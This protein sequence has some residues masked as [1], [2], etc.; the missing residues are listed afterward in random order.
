MPQGDGEVARGRGYAKAA[1][2]HEEEGDREEASRLY[3]KAAEAF[4]AGSKVTR[5]PDQR[6]LRTELA[7][8]FYERGR[9]LKAPRRKRIR[10]G[11]SPTVEEGEK[12]YFIPLEV[13]KVTFRD[14][15]GMER[16]KE[17]I[18]KAIIHPFSHP[19]LYEMYGKSAGESILFYGPPGCGKT[20]IAKAAAG[21]TRSSFI[22]VRIS[23]VLNMWAGESEKNIQRV[24]ASAERHKPAIIFFDEIDGIG[25]R[26]SSSRSTYAKR[27]VN[28]MLIAMDGIQSSKDKILTLAATNEPWALDPALIRPGRFSKLI[29]IPPPDQEARRQIFRLGLEGRRSSEDLDIE[30]LAARTRCY[31]SADIIQICEEAAE[32][33]LEEALRGNPPRPIDQSD[34]EGIIA[35]RRSSLIPWFR[36][37]RKQIDRSG[38]KDIYHELS[39][40]IDGY[41]GPGG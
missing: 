11:E 34:I 22:N 21:E 14:V 33:P 1:R 27:L 8:T 32:I 3:L 40:I 15:G 4:L 31:S 36:M 9:F 26:R 2:R 23:D 25:G 5:E 13:P 6:K 17:E 20:F 29:L 38:E 28:E 10:E 30:A 12:D 7:E 24:F 39:G 37:A 41:E 35:G 18:R 19:E 16:V